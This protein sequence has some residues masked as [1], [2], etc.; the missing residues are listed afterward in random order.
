MKTHRGVFV[1]G[2]KPI[3]PWQFH[4]LAVQYYVKIHKSDSQI[5]CQRVLWAVTRL[6]VNQSV[7]VKNE[8]PIGGEIR[9]DG[10]V[11]REIPVRLLFETTPG[12]PEVVAQ[13]NLKIAADGQLA[14]I[15]FSYTPQVPGEYKLILEAVVQPGELVTTNNRLST[16]VNVLKG[17]LSVLYLE[18]ALR[19]ETTFLKR[20]LSASPDVN[21][22]YNRID[23]VRPE[24]RPG[25]LAECLRPGKYDVYILGDLDST[26]FEAGELESLAKAVYRGAGLIMLGG[27]Y[28]FGPGGYANTPLANVLPVTMEIGP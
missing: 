10:F 28:S 21:V 8:L 26:A 16:F 3:H 25:D 23:A 22:R 11:N 14:P 17:G 13:E 12:K 15:Q 20:A 6:T 19:P 24:T 7:F 5:S 1:N 4:T 27:V 18:G 9:V 2:F